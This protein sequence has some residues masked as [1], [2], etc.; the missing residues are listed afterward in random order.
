MI[1]TPREGFPRTGGD[2]RHPDSEHERAELVVTLGELVEAVSAVADHAVEVAAVVNHLL[3]R[4]AR[5]SA[6]A[7]GR[8]GA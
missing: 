3:E 6:H 5:F 4:R 7:S 2:G 8:D 1:H